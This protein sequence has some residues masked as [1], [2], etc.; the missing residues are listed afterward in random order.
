MDQNLDNKIESQSRI[1]NL[2][3]ENKIKILIFFV[4]SLI[5]AISLVFLQIYKQKKINLI[6]EKYIKAGIFYTAN[7][8]DK[9]KKFFEDVLNSNNS[10]YSSLAL[11]NIIE[12]DLENN[13]DKIL[14]Y[15]KR[16]EKLQKDK[17]QQDILKFKKALFLLKKSKNQKAKKLLRELIDSNSKIKNLAEEILVN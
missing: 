17:D 12:K 11:Y 9:S 7:E 2:Y 5:L 8:K 14:E 10:F 6:S 3:R 1:K 13:E 16:V 15:F 4:G